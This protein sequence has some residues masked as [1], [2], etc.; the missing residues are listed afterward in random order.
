[1]TSKELNKWK[2][3]YER[4]FHTVYQ[5]AFLYL[6]RKED[7]EDAVQAIFLKQMEKGKQFRDEQQERAWYITVTKNY[8]KDVLKSYWKKNVDVGDVPESISEESKEDSLLERI[9]ELPIKY[10]EVLFFFYYEER[11]IREISKFLKKK[12]STIGSRL[13]KAR[14][15]LKEKLEQEGAENER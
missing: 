13:A 1:M 8:C 10:R 9:M 14:A 15:L 3:I 12:E 4:Q 7:V 2:E 6:K 5:V 11:S